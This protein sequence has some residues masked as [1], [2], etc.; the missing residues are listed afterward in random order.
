MTILKS[1]IELLELITPSPIGL[2]L[3]QVQAAEVL[4][5]TKENVSKRLQTLQRRQPEAY[6]NFISL[7]QAARDEDCKAKTP[8]SL[9]ELNLEL[10]EVKRTW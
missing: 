2:G 1:T 6:D 3:S 4:G 9:S 10:L 7:R 5:I 8:V